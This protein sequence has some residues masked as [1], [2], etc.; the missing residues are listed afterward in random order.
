[1]DA[2]TPPRESSPSTYRF[3]ARLAGSYGC[4]LVVE[5]HWRPVIA[6]GEVALRGHAMVFHL[7]EL[8]HGAQARV[9]TMANLNAVDA[10]RVNLAA[11]RS[12]LAAL[13]S[14]PAQPQPP[15]VILPVAWAAARGE[16]GRR[17]LI[18]IAGQ[19]HSALQAIPIAELT[20][21]AV[22]APRE[23]VGQTTAALKPIFGGVL[24]GLSSTTASPRPLMGCGFTGASVDV[25]G[26]CQDDDS[27]ILS[28]TV[29]LLK[30]LGPNV[31]LHGLSSVAQ[32]HHGKSV[33][34]AW[35]SL[36]VVRSGWHLVH[37][38]LESLRGKAEA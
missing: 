15:I 24:A 33:N 21:I 31:L 32:L 3:A 11:L 16:R 35:A 4:D 19:A 12:G 10:E 22:G 8:R 36:D 28:G 26:I 6:L 5:G 38:G 17:E 9:V 27:P 25:S 18:R 20:D 23:L 34:A 13:V 7:K 2:V 14:A 37:A 30:A 29:A 1:M